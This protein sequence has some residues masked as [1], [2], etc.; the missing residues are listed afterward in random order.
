MDT[1]FLCILGCPTMKG[2]HEMSYSCR[3]YS[4]L[5][6]VCF[7]AL[8][9]ASGCRQVDKIEIERDLPIRAW[10]RNLYESE[11]VL[12]YASSSSAAR[13]IA[14][15]ADRAANSFQHLAEEEPRN[16]IYIAVAPG[17]ATSDEMLQAG[18]E[19]LSRVS[20][21]SVPD[22]RKS[23]IGE[24]R[25]KSGD[26]IDGDDVVLRALL[27]MIPGI[28]DSPVKRPPE[29]WKDAVIIPT[30]ARI[31]DGFDTV[32]EFVVEKEQIGFF[33]RLLMAPVIAIAKSYFHK[34]IDSV[35]EAV[36]LGIHAQGRDDWPQERIDKMFE[37]SMKATGFDQLA[38]DLSRRRD[39]SIQNGEPRD[40]NTESTEEAGVE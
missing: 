12:V 26:E 24:A 7:M 4:L 15:I 35:Q 29:I 3:S 1:R 23:M 32:I 36:I 37:E 14:V 38:E 33:E 39:D 20:G 13:E 28:V 31:S 30:A 11:G 16:L 17:D 6:F 19:G 18:L 25:R 40:Q 21:K 22:I 9:Q 2:L 27:G 34:I 5:L 8:F 10:D